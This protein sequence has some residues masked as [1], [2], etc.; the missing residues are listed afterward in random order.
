MTLIIRR[1]QRGGTY[2]TGELVGYTKAQLEQVFGPSEEASLDGKS[3]FSWDF[4]V[5]DG[6]DSFHCSIWD[7]KGSWK[8]NMW[9]TYGPSDLIRQAITEGLTK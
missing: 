5:E 6:D 7:W 2:K 9:S 8:E 4:D 1:I 3:K